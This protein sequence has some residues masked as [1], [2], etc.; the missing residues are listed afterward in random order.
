M[1]NSKVKLLSYYQGWQKPKVFKK[2]LGF[3]GFLVF[4]G[5]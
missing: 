2:D 3:L 4:L 5:F 1:K